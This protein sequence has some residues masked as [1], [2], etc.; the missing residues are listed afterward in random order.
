M[1]RKKSCDLVVMN[2]ILAYYD[3]GVSAIKISKFLKR[4]HFADW[5]TMAIISH[6]R[7]IRGDYIASW[8][9]G[10]DPVRPV[11]SKI[12]PRRKG[13][14]DRAL[15]Y[16]EKIAEWREETNVIPVSFLCGMCCSINV[17]VEGGICDSCSKLFQ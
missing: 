9:R 7:K 11:K 3:A 2:A 1:G 10:D 16:S 13:E 12:L 15:V 8:R 4:R 5:S 17:D 6:V 14:T